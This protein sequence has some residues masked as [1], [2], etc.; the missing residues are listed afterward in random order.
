MTG[1]TEKFKALAQEN[2]RR[3]WCRIEVGGE[4]FLDDR[5]TG[6]DMDNVAHPDYFTIGA[7][8]SDRF[9]FSVRYGG[10]LTAGAEVKPFISFDNEEWCPLGVYY[11]S[12]RYVREDYVSV[13]CYDRMYSLDMDYTG[14]L[15]L[16]TDTAAVLEELCGRYGIECEEYGYAYPVTEYPSPATVRDMIGWIAAMNRSCAK[17][18]RNG[19]LVMKN[20]MDSG[21]VLSDNNCM[22]IQRNMGRSVVTCVRCDTGREILIAGNGA[23]ISTIDIYDPLMTQDRLEEIF[24]LLRPMWFYGAEITMQGMPFL[25]AGDGIQLLHKGM[26][27]PLIIGGISYKYDGG[28]TARL[29]SKNKTDSD[30]VVYSEDMRAALERLKTLWYEQS[31]DAQIALTPEPVTVAEFTFSVN[32]AGFAQVDINATVEQFTADFLIA[33]VYVNGVQAPRNAIQSL[34]GA[35]QELLHYYHLAGGLPAGENT[36]R[37]T[38]RTKTGEAYILP[39][40]LFATLVVHGGHGG[41]SVRDRVALY[42]L[43]AGITLNKGVFI[44]E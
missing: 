11:I 37:V 26:L 4:V 18:D 41:Q 36:I 17:F 20:G 33:E 7:T 2:G 30:T 44:P 3:V 16:P 13:T 15:P 14:T 21:F 35:G 6:F 34:T 1:V 5:I 32:T 29:Y 22:D 40:R 42:E 27:Y 39:S 38:M 25:E 23:E 12:R 19:A 8:C 43:L 28:L 10:E 24:H 9:H 31:N